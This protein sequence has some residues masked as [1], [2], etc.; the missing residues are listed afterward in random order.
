MN[1]I[2]F[3][4]FVLKTIMDNMELFIRYTYQMAECARLMINRQKSMNIK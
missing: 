2:I 4:V 3:M 1:K